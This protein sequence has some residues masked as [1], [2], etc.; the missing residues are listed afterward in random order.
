MSQ[1][2]SKKIIIDL[3]KN[4]H[5]PPGKNYSY[6]M[7]KNDNRV[8]D[9]QLLDTG[10][11]MYADKYGAM[12]KA[13]SISDIANILKH[14]L[15]VNVKNKPKGENGWKRVYFKSGTNKGKSLDTV[16]KKY[17]NPLKKKKNKKKK[18]KD[19]IP[20]RNRNNDIVV[21]QDDNLETHDD[22]IRKMNEEHAKKMLIL[23]QE[24]DILKA[25]QQIL[26]AQREE[27]YNAKQH[28]KRMREL[29]SA[30]D[31]DSDSDS[32]DDWDSA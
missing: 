27:E 11:W 12:K 5:L 1:S 22:I 8:R 2:R 16:L 24:K 23:Q 20:Q 18:V 3:I 19:S 29:D 13:T 15:D 28:E 32:D 17:R 14:E 30:S 25:K 9:V 7:Y 21:I 10:D 31:S 4:N 26:A 6:K